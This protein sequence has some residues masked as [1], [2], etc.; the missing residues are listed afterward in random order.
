M[1]PAELWLAEKLGFVKGSEIKKMVEEGWNEIGGRMPINTSGGLVA[2]GHPIGATGVAQI[3]ELVWQLRGEAG[4][5]QVEKPMIGL[6]QN[7]GGRIDGDHAAVVV[8]ILKR[9]EPW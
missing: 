3:C 2:R 9:S 8:T 1:A 5:R 7:G 4:K 6:A